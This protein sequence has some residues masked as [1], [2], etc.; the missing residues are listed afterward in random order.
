MP[1]LLASLTL[2]L[3]VTLAG[4]EPG[5][6]EKPAAAGGD[7]RF[8]DI[9]DRLVA[10]T[11][12]RNPTTATALGI[13]D[14][15]TALEDVSR[16]AVE[17]EVAALKQFRYELSAI[18][19]STLSLANQLDLGQAL[20]AVDSRMLEWQIV[21]GWTKNPDLYSTAITQTA[22][23][24]IKRNFAPLEVRLRALTQRERL[25]PGNLAEARKN[26]ENPPSIYTD[27]AIEQLD[28]DIGFFKSSVPAAFASVTDQALLDQF[29]QANQGVI[30]ALTQ[31]KNW[32]QTDLRPRAKGSFALGGEALA[33]K[34]R[35]NELVTDGLPRL[36]A[37]AEADLAKNDAE[38][39]KVAAQIA[40]GRTAR[41]AVTQI[42]ADH[43]PADKLLSVTQSQLDGLRQFIAE[44][45]LV[46]IPNAAPAQ[47]I[48][49]PPFMR[50]MTT[51]SMDTPGPF[52][53]KAT[54]AY[55]RVTLPDPAWKPSQVESYL[56]AWYLPEIVN[57]SVHE[58]Y[59]GH[60]TQ[61]LYG[62]S[63]P[64]KIRKVFSANT[65]VEGWAHYCE[66]MMLDEGLANADPK[67]RLAQLQDALL[68][69][70]RF[71]V[72][73]Q[74]HTGK[75]TVE[76]AEKMFEEKGYQQPEVALAEAKRGTS[77]PTYGYY[78]LGKLMILKLRADYHA[79]QG[80]KFSLQDFHDR[81]LKLGPLPLP[82]IRKALL[83]EAGEALPG[84]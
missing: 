72:G 18:D 46:T 79:Q 38:F 68:R 50:A 12:K 70:V 24:M 75:I 64:S 74:L 22:F 2:A 41:E 47:V 51:A 65:N 39:Q 37:I 3:A 5:G 42:S 69:D 53:A 67:Y 17:A 43:P 54:E 32:L 15:D 4:C 63:F 33:A 80:S 19:L 26:L 31:Y 10:D 83:G 82:L 49:T 13:H 57:V 56:R 45:H 28:G 52:E 34:F 14:Y 60:Y 71:I 25:M 76:Q 21:R 81:F 29:R 6:Q 11:L 7:A 30:D 66:Q 55:Y 62:P 16:Q 78:T 77:D 1:R 61:F 36:Q 35:A 59:P 40:P 8:Q 9:A 27:I 48:E 20:A 73:I 58:V 23:V 84:N 44:R